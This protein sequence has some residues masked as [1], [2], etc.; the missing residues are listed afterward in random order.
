MNLFF[1]RSIGTAIPKALKRY[2]KPAIGVEY[3][4]ECF[5]QEAEDEIWLPEVGRRGWFVIGQDH[6]YHTKPNELAALKAYSIGVFYMWGCEATK[7]ETMRVFARA[8]DR[9]V[10]ASENTPTPFL[11]H[12]RRNGSLV[13]HPIP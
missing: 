4:Q 9:I 2:L 3:H 5:A 1:D 12:V 8:Y 6:S 10:A 7:W 11:Y 13:S